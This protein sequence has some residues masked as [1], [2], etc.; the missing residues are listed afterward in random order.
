MTIPQPSP[1]IPSHRLAGLGLPHVN[2]QELR[3]LERDTNGE[4]A[5]VPS[6]HGQRSAHTDKQKPRGYHTNRS[7]VFSAIDR[8]EPSGL[9]P[10]LRNKRANQGVEVAYDPTRE[11]GGFL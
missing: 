3:S 4:T 6:P 5:G 2:T 7:D 10:R 8:A 1:G 9:N 11:P